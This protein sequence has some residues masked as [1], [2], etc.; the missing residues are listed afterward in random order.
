MASNS[1]SQHDDNA[2]LTRRER[3]KREVR[4]RILEAAETLFEKQGPQATKVDEICELADVAQK[5]FFNHFAT[6]QHLVSEIA[7]SF[8]GR[9]F[10]ALD[11]LRQSEDTAGQRLTTFFA[12]LA[13]RSE[14]AGPM[15]REL[16]LEV[17]R[18][19]HL[20]HHEPAQMR[21]VHDAFRSFLE[22][23]HGEL[24]ADHQI[25]T[26]TELVVGTFYVLMLN[27]VSIDDY[28]LHERSVAAGRLLA[29]A[30][31]TQSRD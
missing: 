8:L 13:D 2:D 22:G 31:T 10:V 16:V 17:I 25:E 24:R 4:D 14:A 15:H 3:R 7:A 19:A 12:D 9:L 23:S 29:D 5:T 18:V 11:E 21:F 20:Q 6:K 26:L 1:H 28:P 27:W 30:V